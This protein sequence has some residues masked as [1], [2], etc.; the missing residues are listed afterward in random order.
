MIKYILILF[1][2]LSFGQASNQM[3]TFT[4]AQGLGFA[5]NSGQS[6]VTS[7]Q[8]MTKSDALAKYTLDASAMGAYAINQLVPK[9]T[10]AT[11]SFTLLG[12]IS[13]SYYTTA[14]LACVPTSFGSQGL[15]STSTTLAV[16]I[17]V[18]GN[19]SALIQGQNYFYIA[20]INAN[21]KIVQ[22]NNSGVVLQV[23][24]CP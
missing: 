21:K 22:I 5:L 11:G 6:S 3:V 19:G 24:T 4:A 9:S 1:T 10:W 17:T 16:G 18:Y 23:L 14:I 13:T 15:Y 7:D 8:C 20:T 12:T 2:F